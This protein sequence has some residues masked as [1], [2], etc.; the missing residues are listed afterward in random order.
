[1]KQLEIVQTLQWIRT[2]PFNHLKDNVI[3]LDMEQKTL[4]AFPQ[5]IR[6][7]LV[8]LRN[9]QIEVGDICYESMQR[10]QMLISDNEAFGELKRRLNGLQHSL[11]KI[12]R[13][14]VLSGEIP[15]PFEDQDVVLTDGEEL[16]FYTEAFYFSAWRIVL[17]VN[18]LNTNQNGDKGNWKPSGVTIVRNQLIEHPEGRGDKKL[19]EEKILINSM[20]YDE[21]KGPVIKGARWEHQAGLNCDHGLYKNAQEFCTELNEQLNDISKK[22]NPKRIL[23]GGEAVMFHAPRTN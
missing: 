23:K 2:R 14:R 10:S 20:S 18:Y 12:A 3:C 22:E 6:D 9:A 19:D 15:Q 1:L 16:Y 21:I 7:L 4:E 13:N 5:T 11:V 17:L 8:R